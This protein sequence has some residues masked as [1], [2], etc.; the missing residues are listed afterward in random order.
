MSEPVVELLAEEWSVLD[1]LCADLTEA[2]WKTPTALPGWTVQDCLSHVIGVERMLMGD[3]APDIDVSDLSHISDPISANL[4]TWVAARRPW[5]G[6]EVLAE[7]REQVSRRLTALRA[8]TTADFDRVG[9]SPIGEVPYRDF[10]AVRVFD[11]W[12]HEQDMRRALDR[13]GHLQGPVVDA[14]LERFRAAIGFVVGKRAGAP[15]GT[16]VVIVTDSPDVVLP[17][18]V[19]GRAR[20]ADSVPDDPTVRIKVPFT[21]FVA[22][23]GGRWDAAQAEAAGGVTIEGDEALGRAVLAGMAF[24]P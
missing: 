4:E 8:M 15:D 11:C 3:P 14:A 2:E 16:S 20:L 7:Y 23:G 21:T 9:F 10:M 22:L 12:M 18:V 17:V 19:E 24:T 6:A 13:P 5:S 1:T